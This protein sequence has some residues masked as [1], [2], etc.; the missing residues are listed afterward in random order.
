MGA[1][2]RTTCFTTVEEFGEVDVCP[3]SAVKKLNFRKM[4]CSVMTVVEFHSEA[5]RQIFA[6]K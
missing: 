1:R 5:G 4:L 2:F 3:S 6:F